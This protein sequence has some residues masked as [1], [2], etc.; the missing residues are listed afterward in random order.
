MFCTSGQVF[1]A[2]PKSATAKPSAESKALRDKEIIDSLELINLQLSFQKNRYDSLYQAE[3]F[4]SAE[5]RD[6]VIKLDDY[7]KNLESN[8]TYIKN[9]NLKLNQ[10]NRI[11]IV[12][13]SFVAVLLLVTLIFFLRRMRKKPAGLL[14]TSPEGIIAGNKSQNISVSFEDKLQQL[15]RLGQLREKGLLSEEEFLAQKQ[16]ILSK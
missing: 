8:A 4:T 14:P 16:S 6:Q 5:L 9:E 1:A 12:F 10:S 15:E 13:N 2:Q 7:R 11:L 3:K